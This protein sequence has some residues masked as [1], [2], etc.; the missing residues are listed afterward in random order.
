MFL[1]SDGR[2][3]AEGALKGKWLRE[4]DNARHANNQINRMRIELDF[5]CFANPERC[6]FPIEAHRYSRIRSGLDKRL[7]CPRC[8]AMYELGN[9][10]WRV[11][12]VQDE[13]GV[14]TELYSA[15]RDPELREKMP[16]APVPKA[17]VLAR[18]PYDPPSSRP[19]DKD[20][21]PGD[22]TLRPGHQWRWSG[23][24]ARAA[25]A[26]S[27]EARRR[28]KEARDAARDNGGG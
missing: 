1:C 3:R 24:R 20:R 5:I 26:K 8:K 14:F 16:V 22:G 9:G 2:S 23:A 13:D 19:I 10:R 25:Q 27:V 21:R 18:M 12:G 28:N 6:H 4:W 15:S 11:I 17:P 7:S